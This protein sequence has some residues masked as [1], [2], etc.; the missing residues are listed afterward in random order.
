V[1][2]DAADWQPMSIPW[3]VLG[4]QTEIKE[5]EFKKSIIGFTWKIEGYSSVGNYLSIRKVSCIH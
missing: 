3:L 5:E 2:K 1:L 4:M